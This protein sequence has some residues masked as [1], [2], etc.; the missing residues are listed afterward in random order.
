MPPLLQAGAPAPDFKASD[1]DGKTVT[2]SDLRGRPLVLAFY[3][4]DWSPV[5]GDQMAL[6]NEVLPIFREYGAEMLGVSPETLTADLAL[7]EL[8]ELRQMGADSF[9]TVEL[10][11]V[12]EEEFDVRLS[13]DAA[14]KI[15]TFADLVRYL[16]DRG[17]AEPPHG[18]AA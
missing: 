16:E 18:P 7:G 17:N 11:M 5:C 12:L 8:S 1:Q 10:I 3:P 15:V 9:Y 13:D 4:A 14:E 2:L 6:Y